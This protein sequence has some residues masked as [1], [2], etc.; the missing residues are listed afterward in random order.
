MALHQPGLVAILTSDV[1]GMARLCG[2]R[3]RTHQHL[4]LPTELNEM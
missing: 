3:V 1:D 4:A 2:D